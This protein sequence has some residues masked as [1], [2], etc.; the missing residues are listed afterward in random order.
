M[1]IS[2]RD[3]LTETVFRKG[4]HKKVPPDVL[5]RALK[6]LDRVDAAARTG[7]LGFPPSNHFERL[8]GTKPPRYSIRVN[9]QYRVT[10]EW[11]GTDAENVCFE[12]YH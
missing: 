1:I 6:Q 11:T 7:D 9:R 3:K 10:F 2:F 8:V 12:D 4:C 5:G